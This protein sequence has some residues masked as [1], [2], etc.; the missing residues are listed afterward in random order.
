MIDHRTKSIFIHMPCTG[1]TSIES[2]LLN[3]RP[4]DI[5]EKHINSLTAKIIYKQ[6]WNDYFKFSFVRNPWGRM[7]SMMKFRDKSLY[8]IKELDGKINL[9][10]YL[11]IHPFIEVDP[12][13]RNYSK[14]SYIKGSVYQNFL[15]EDLDFV[16][17]FENLQNDFNQVCRELNIEPQELP[18]INSSNYKTP[19]KN[20]FNERSNNQI[21]KI[22][23]KDILYYKYNEPWKN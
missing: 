23:E 9:D 1:G 16:G 14:N 5:K 7:L 10:E 20:Y 19:I 12:R 6:Y 18:I 13:A 11:K 8:G 22:F 2:A 17:K 3:G 4:V 15:S 21:R